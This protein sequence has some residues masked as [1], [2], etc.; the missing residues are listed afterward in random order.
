[1]KNETA[2]KIH[3]KIIDLSLILSFFIFHFSFFISIA[4]GETWGTKEM[5]T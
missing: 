4:P 2:N 3:I 1:M 5:T